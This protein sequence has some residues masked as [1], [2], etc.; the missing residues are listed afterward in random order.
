M[1]SAQQSRGRLTLPLWEPEVVCQVVGHVMVQTVDQVEHVLREEHSVV[2]PIQNPLVVIQPHRLI[3][4]E[5]RQGRPAFSSSA[6]QQ[7][8]VDVA[9][10]AEAPSSA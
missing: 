2:V 6:A 5:R 10:Q 1:K 7:G 8:A 9:V 3:R 4:P